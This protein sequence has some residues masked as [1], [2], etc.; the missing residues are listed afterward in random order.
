MQFVQ[1]NPMPAV[2]GSV[3]SEFCFGRLMSMEKYTDAL[4]TMS[5]KNAN[6]TVCTK[7]L[8]KTALTLLQAV[9]VGKKKSH[10]ATQ[11]T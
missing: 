5:G 7:L 6:G 10:A 11:L 9:P 8:E 1:A 3:D 4:Q 2:F